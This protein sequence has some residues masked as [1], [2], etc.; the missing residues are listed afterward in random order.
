ML[1]AVLHFALETT[2][3]P[4][5]SSLLFAVLIGAQ[6][7]ALA[8]LGWDNGIRR[9]DRRLLAIMA[10]ATPL[11]SA[12]MLILC[13]YATP[14]IGIVL[15]CGLIVAA[16]ARVFEQVHVRPRNRTRTELGGDGGKTAAGALCQRA[17]CLLTAHRD[18]SV[19]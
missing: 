6:P 17:F 9:G 8:A 3:T 12:L 4:S 16:G 7:L 5:A 19:W 1:G 13:G 10:Y 11:V 2:V 15:G 18:Q 14:S